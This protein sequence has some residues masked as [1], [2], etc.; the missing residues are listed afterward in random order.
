MKA[1]RLDQDYKLE[2]FFERSPDLLIIAGYDGYFRKINP[3]VSQLLG[4]TEAELFAKPIKDFIYKD[5]QELTA[6]RRSHLIQN[7]PLLNFENR[8]LTKSGEIV[9]LS[10]TSMPM[11]DEQLVYAIAK[12]ITHRKKLETQRNILLT[13]LT[14]VNKELKQFSYVTAHD[15]RAPVNNILSIF[16]LLD[17]SKIQDKQTSAFIDKLK[18]ATKNLKQTL[19]NYVDR[20]IQNDK[21]SLPLEQLSLS[22]MLQHVQDSIATLI[23][24]ANA[25]FEVDFSA[26]D[27]LLFNKAYLESIFLNLIT[28]S[29]KYAKPD[30]APLIRISSQI[31]EGACQLIFADNGLGLDVEQF[32]TKLFGL[33]QKFHQHNDSKGIGLYLVYNHVTNLGGKIEVQSQVNEGATFI[34]TFKQQA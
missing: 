33:H 27:I 9:W 16:N 12:N 13:N 26:V 8:Y 24:N 3:A 25:T 22:E 20:L 32:K 30:Q 11:D 31:N 7:H 19:N 2:P 23:W 15:L 28:N 1:D 21:Q 5:D 29:I 14:K 34:I 17:T 4:Y 10:W 6:K 18:S